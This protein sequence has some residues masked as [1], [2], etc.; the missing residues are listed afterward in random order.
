MPDELQELENYLKDNN[1]IAISREMSEKKI[2]KVPV[3]DNDIYKYF[4]ITG[5][6]DSLN[7]K[8]IANKIYFINIHNSVLEFKRPYFYKETNSMRFGRLYYTKGFLNDN[9]KWQEKPDEFLQT[10]DKLFK[11]FGKTYKAV[12]LPEYKGF[13]ITQNV[14]EKMESEDL[15]LLIH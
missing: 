1:L 12:K 13:L 6:E 4:I 8:F 11:W 10:A 14:K 2:K 9:D 7:I 5:S 15:K 3:V